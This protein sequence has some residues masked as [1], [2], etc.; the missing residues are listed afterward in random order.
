MDHLSIY[1]SIAS[2][3]AS[4][5]FAAHCFAKAGLDM[6]TKQF[7]L[8]LGPRQIRVNSVNPTGIWT[9]PT[10][11][12]VKHQPDI[13]TKFASITP[14]GRFCEVHEVIEPIM[15]L[16]SEHSTMVTGTMHLVDGGVMSNIPV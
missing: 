11:E 10:K 15:Y 2:I 14:L 8:E 6:V 7:A 13:E 4:K 9:E 16:L 12:L 1:F 5:G 3:R